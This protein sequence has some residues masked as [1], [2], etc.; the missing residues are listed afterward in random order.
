MR[1]AKRVWHRTNH[2]LK[3][4]KRMTKTDSILLSLSLFFLL[5]QR[6]SFLS[7]S[8]L[9]DPRSFPPL[10]ESKKEE[11]NVENRLFFATRSFAQILF[12]AWRI[13][14]RGCSRTRK[15]EREREGEQGGPSLRSGVSPIKARRRERTRNGHGR[16]TRN[17]R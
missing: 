13:P 11:R 6:F 7:F 14:R 3:V 8:L 17:K 15:R 5:F 9:D 1:I 10:E 4:Q 12:E 2:H 16:E